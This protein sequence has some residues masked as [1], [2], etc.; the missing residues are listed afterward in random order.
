MINKLYQRGEKKPAVPGWFRLPNA[1][2]DTSF[3]GID[4][5]A[6]LKVLL[7]LARYANTEG[8]CFPSLSTISRLTALNQ[9]SVSR[10]IKSLVNAKYISRHKPGSRTQA[11]TYRVHIPDGSGTCTHACT[12]TGEVHAPTH[13]GTCTDALVKRLKIKTNEKY[14]A[15]SQNSGIS[16]T[17]DGGFAVDLSTHAQLA[18]SFPDCD[19]TAELRSADAWLRANPRK[20]NKTN[21]HRFFTGWLLRRFNNAK[22]FH[23]KSTRSAPADRW[24]DRTEA[25]RSLTL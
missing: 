7:T 2:C 4:S 8:L 22:P 1:L 24:A 6:Q 16:W 21:W 10:A 20:A 11:T 3:P 25:E 5:A 17:V 14:K 12:C 19:L 9:S 15:Q 23:A 18:K 13:K